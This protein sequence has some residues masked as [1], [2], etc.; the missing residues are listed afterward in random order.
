[1]WS[2]CSTV[3]EVQ[4]G[5]MQIQYAIPWF[6]Q[7]KCKQPISHLA[8]ITS[9]ECLWIGICIPRPE[10]I[11]SNTNLFNIAIKYSC[12]FSDV[13]ILESVLEYC[14]QEK[15]FFSLSLC[16]LVH[17]PYLHAWFE[18]QQQSKLFITFLFCN[19]ACCKRRNACVFSWPV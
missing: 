9:G 2:V 14:L 17:L 5:N 15:C 4:I 7:K 13:S 12:K 6:F 8:E 1:M 19:K 18:R 3:I 16:L 11:K 10:N